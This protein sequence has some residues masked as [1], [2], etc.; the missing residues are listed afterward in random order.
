MSDAIATGASLVAVGA[1]PGAPAARIVITAT[2]D[3]LRAHREDAPW[4]KKRFDAEI[5]AI[6]A[7]R[8]HVSVLDAGGAL[9]GIALDGSPIGSIPIGARPRSLVAAATGTLAALDAAAVHL[10]DE[11]GT[12]ALPFEV[13]LA[14]AFDGRGRRLVV[15]GERRRAAL[16]ADGAVEPLPDPPEEVRALVWSKADAWIALGE[17]SLLHLDVAER[18][19]TTLSA[20]ETGH[21]L[22]RSPRGTRLAMAM[23]TRHVDVVAADTMATLRG[24]TYPDCYQ[25]EGALLSVTGLAFLDERRL[26]VGLS[27][28]NANILDLV[29]GTALRIDPFPDDPQD[30]WVFIYDGNILVAG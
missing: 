14:A 1:P 11:G 21:R 8:E 22:A 17:R 27:R 6:A 7:D 13:P 23:G 28:G 16:I 3:E 30:R 10:V 12:R 25:D 15:A 18:A 26:V 9:H 4:W 19:W 20:R 29:D 24:V 5:V 2:G